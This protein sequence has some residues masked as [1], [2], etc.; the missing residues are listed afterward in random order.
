[1]QREINRL[2][3]SEV[4]Y[5]LYTDIYLGGNPFQALQPV[6]VDRAEEKFRIEFL[7]FS[8]GEMKR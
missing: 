4:I 6:F 2:H 5:G 3:V 8:A 7:P 1:M